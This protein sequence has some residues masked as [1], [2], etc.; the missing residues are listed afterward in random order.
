MDKPAYQVVLTGGLVSGISREAAL[1]SLARLFQTS[2]ARLVEVLDGG[3]CPIDDLFQADEAA[4]LQKRLERMGVRTRIDRVG[5]D[6][7]SLQR[8]GLHLQSLTDP[9]DAGLMSCPACG[10][11]QLVAKRCDECGVVFA[12]FNRRRDARPQ[13]AHAAA[14]SAA[15]STL[16]TA[17]RARD[18]HAHAHAEWR[19]EWMDDGNEMPTE[20]YH[21][22]VFMG[23]HSEHLSTICRRMVLVGWRTRLLFSWAGGAMFSPYLWAMYRKMWAWGAVI[24]VTEVLIPVVLITL[25]SKEGVSGALV[26]LGIGLAVANRLFWPAVLK[27]LYCRHARHT[28]MFMN[29]AAATTFASDVQIANRGGTSRTSVFV[30]LVVAAVISLLAWSIVDSL[31]ARWLLPVQPF[32]AQDLPPADIP[33]PAPAVT[34]AADRPGAGAAQADAVDGQ[35]DLTLVNQNSWVATRNRLRL[36]GQRLSAWFAVDGRHQDPAQL[37]LEALARAVPLEPNRTRDGWGRPIVFESDGAG[38][39]LISP[40]PDGVLGNSDDVDYR[41][42]LDR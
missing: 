2:A 11:R 13:P 21:I 40:G 28:I 42:I 18:I 30:G 20:H 29:R 8:S 36:L 19:E 6:P 22:N 3:E 41:R 37:D 10:H 25:G 5:E 32:A 38:Y 7:Q 17:P 39:R 31:H 15:S 34:P 9:A 27:H 16:H 1:V 23:P 4:N 26:S 35:R 12:E 14:T 24:F 33:P